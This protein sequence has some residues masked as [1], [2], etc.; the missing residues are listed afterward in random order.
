MD[1]L[2]LDAAAKTANVQ[3]VPI[4]EPGPNELLI[5]VEAVA[6][7]PVDALYTINPLARSGRVVGTDFAGTVKA[8][9][10]DV[11]SLNST[12]QLGTRVAGFLQG[13]CSA[14][15]RPG[16]FANYLIVPHDLVWRVQ[17]GMSLAD[18]A[19]VSLTALTAAQGLFYRLGLPAP[20][21]Y[22][23]PQTSDSTT[24][25]KGMDGPLT[26]FI[27]GASTSVGLN[28][29]Q[30]LQLS[31]KAHSIQ[32]RL[33]GAA[34]PARHAMLSA[35]PYNFTNL[36]DYRDA[37]WPAQ[38]RTLTNDTGV[39]VAYDC[40]SEGPSVATVA[41]TLTSTGKIAV[42]RSR[43]GK[44]WAA[45]PGALPTEPVYGAV[46]EGLGE[47]IEY[48]GFVVERSPPARAFA[49]E[50]YRFFSQGSEVLPNPIRKMPGG[51]ERI[52]P[53]GFKLLGPGS[54]EQRGGE[55]TEEWMRP[56]SGEKLVYEI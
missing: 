54:M 29:A 48:Q 25:P 1:A 8:L 56:I 24:L 6:L 5:H 21:S 44:A 45:E 52:V 28:A 7:N 33:I 39:D 11:P 46:W 4:P 18:A 14:N 32:L 20:F 50:F 9:G 15:D 23:K 17:E 2:I 41:S 40:I 26:V 19:S 47:R 12:I 16:A 31:A 10:A 34:S 43:A 38:V 3:Q 55:R 37:T 30:L 22:D 35:A 27:Y 49:V 53:D 36:V 13:V 42:V 51:L